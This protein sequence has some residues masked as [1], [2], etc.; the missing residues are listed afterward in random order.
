[1]FTRPQLSS[2][3]PASCLVD[4]HRLLSEIYVRP[5]NPTASLLGPGHGCN[6][7]RWNPSFP[8]L[9]LPRKRR[10]RWH[11]PGQPRPPDWPS[12]PRRL[13]KGHGRCPPGWQWG[14]SG[15]SRVTPR[16][17]VPN[18]RRQRRPPLATP[19]PSA[20]W[21]PWR[22]P[23]QW[24]SRPGRGF[25]RGRWERRCPSCD[26]RPRTA[27]RPAKSSGAYGW[28]RRCHIP[29][30]T[31]SR[32]HPLERRYP[33]HPSWRDRPALDWPPW[34]WWTWRMPV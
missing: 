17:P 5:T 8:A 30:P 32:S 21:R 10:A 2:P 15:T 24:G 3:F 7:C 34:H 26:F 18:F 33:A 16:P 23:L 6:V 12:P 1:M 20:R 4:V 29:A 27:S 11:G 31:N 19:W 22:S 13:P 25:P 9:S 14:H 28:N